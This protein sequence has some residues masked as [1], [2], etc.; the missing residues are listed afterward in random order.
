MLCAG[1]DTCGNPPSRSWAAWQASSYEGLPQ[2]GSAC[3]RCQ[4]LAV[5]L[6]T[7]GS[8]NRVTKS[9]SKK[10]RL[11][12]FPYITVMPPGCLIV[13]AEVHKHDFCSCSGCELEGVTSVLKVLLQALAGLTQ[14]AL[15]SAGSPL[16]TRHSMRPLRRLLALRYQ[17][18]VCGCP[19]ARACREC[20]THPPGSPPPDHSTPAHPSR[21]L[22]LIRRL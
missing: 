11:P 5:F 18:R 3:C 22:P 20:P 9:H 16:R 19:S 4:Q 10:V 14:C 7:T 8:E 12:C 2:A 6:H 17:S 13:A 21:R 15:Q 1:L